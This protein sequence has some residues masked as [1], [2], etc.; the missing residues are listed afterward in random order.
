MCG[1]FGCSLNTEGTVST[2]LVNGIQKL[3]YRGYDSWGI[4]ID[5]VVVRRSLN[6]VS[7]PETTGRI[8]IA[9]TRWATHGEPCIRNTHPVVSSDGNWSV[10][11]NGI[12]QNYDAFDFE[13]TTDT[14][15]EVL[16]Y[17]AQKFYTPGMS[18]PDVIKKVFSVVQ[19]SYAVLFTSKHFKHEIVATCNGSP[20]VFGTNID[21]VFF[22]SDHIAFVDVCK[23]Y[24]KMENGDM[25]HVHDGTYTIENIRNFHDTIQSIDVSN[26][27]EHFMLKEILEQPQ[28]LLKMYKGRVYKDRVILGGLEPHRETLDKSKHWTLIACGSSFNACL[29]VRSLLEDHLDKTITC[30]VASDFFIRSAHVCKD[31]VYFIVSQ[32]GETK[33]CIMAAEHIIKNGGVCFGINNR[34]GSLLDSRTVAG[35]HLNI[36][37]ECAVA[38]TKSFTSTVIVFRMIAEMIR[39]KNPEFLLTVPDIIEQHIER[40]THEVIPEI[41]DGL[42]VLGDGP[43]YG[44]SREIALKIQ[45]ILYVKAHATYGFEMKHGPLALI[46]SNSRFVYFGTHNDVPTL[47]K[48]RGANGSSFLLYNKDPWL[49][50]IQHVISYQ[51]FIYTIAKQKGYSIDRPR[52]LAK[53]VTV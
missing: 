14:D 1:I 6:E 18:F 26:T 17:L 21:G 37:P 7:C 42:W 20:L 33:D 25:I 46:D 13:R 23:R 15:T 27:E 47:L 3:L 43:G 29:C 45:E 39:P 9:H 10:V 4:S 28:S 11:H 31:T 30:E 44:M 38:A 40:C 53:S 2:L 32:S 19:G 35:V 16:V 12:I 8:G 48:S 41:S 22:G 5:N 50:I 36:G 51:Y 52:N 49:F 34:P 24:M